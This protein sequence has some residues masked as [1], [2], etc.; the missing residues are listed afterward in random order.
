MHS[1]PWSPASKTLRRIEIVQV[2]LPSSTNAS[3]QNLVQEF[4]FLNHA[5]GVLNEQQQNIGGFRR[6]RDSFVASEKDTSS[7]V[8]AEPAEFIE[9]STHISHCPYGL[10]NSVRKISASAKDFYNPGTV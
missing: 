2:R 8:Q 1:C 4:L 7:T 10:K 5:P 6:K 3:C 9:R